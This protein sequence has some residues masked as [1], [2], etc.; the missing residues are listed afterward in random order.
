MDGTTLIVN[1]RSSLALMQAG[2][3][4]AQWALVDMTGDAA[5]E[6]LMTQRL[7]SNGLSTVGTGVLRITGSGPNV[8]T[9][10]PRP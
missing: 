4:T 8:S 9:L 2:I 3:P 7:L 6:A 5:T 1:T 10:I